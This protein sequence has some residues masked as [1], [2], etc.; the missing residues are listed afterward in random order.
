MMSV[1]AATVAQFATDAICIALCALYCAFIAIQ[2]LITVSEIVCLFAIP[3]SM[4]ERNRD[5]LGAE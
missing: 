1:D 3:A 2:H 5:A 4:L